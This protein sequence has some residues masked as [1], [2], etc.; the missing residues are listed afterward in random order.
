[1][2]KLGFCLL[3]TVLVQASFARADENLL[4][5]VK[6]AETLPKGS[7]EL[8]QILTSRD[9]KGA[10][11]Y[12]A[13]DSKTEVEYGAT[14]SLSLSGSLQMLQVEMSGLS[15][16]GYLP[17]DNNL[18]LRPSGVEAGLKYNFLS[19][20]KDDIGLSS[21][22]SFSYNWLDRHS[23]QNKDSYSMEL[24]FIA[25]KYF[26]E[27]EVVWSSNLGFE[28]T[29]ARRGDLNDLPPGFDWPV[30]PEVEI[31]FTA[32]TGVAYRFMPN[33]FVGAEALFESEYETEVGTERWTVF[34]GPSLHYGSEKWWATLTWI[35]QV[36]GGGE[37]FDAQDDN[38][39]H[40]IE[41]TKYETRLKVGFNF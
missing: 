11:K 38:N 20:A 16:D 19:P 27:G 24:L 28:T 39:L 40:L 34:T 4:G 33:W 35:Q 37:K 41:K 23:G 1:M 36:S 17:K 21:Y 15:V 32:D 2:K 14:D 5:Y 12:H 31:G 26:L 10:G 3:V 25:Q 9:N 7:W 22:L 6:G 29:Y 30:E 13:L 8:Y 18:S